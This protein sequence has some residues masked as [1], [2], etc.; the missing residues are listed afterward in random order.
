MR[1][2]RMAGCHDTQL[3]LIEVTSMRLWSRR[4]SM[5]LPCLSSVSMTWM[6]PISTLRRW[7]LKPSNLGYLQQLDAILTSWAVPELILM[8]H[9]AGQASAW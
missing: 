4:M 6:R 5:G 7:S 1:T 3:K 9:G 8:C 2:R